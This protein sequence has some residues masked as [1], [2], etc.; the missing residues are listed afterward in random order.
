MYHKAGLLSCDKCTPS[1]LVTSMAWACLPRPDRRIADVALAGAKRLDEE[2]NRCVCVCVCVTR[3]G[4]CLLTSAL[5]VLG[6][7]PW[8]GP[9]CLVLIAGLLMWLCRGKK[10]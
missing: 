1:S 9:A 2:R 3:Q 7:F 8:P 4:C 10:I 5:F 6:N